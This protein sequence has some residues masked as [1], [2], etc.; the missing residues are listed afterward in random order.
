[1]AAL[2]F[3]VL[4]IAKVLLAQRFAPAPIPAR[5]DFTAQTVP[6]APRT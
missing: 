5:L 1:M 2:F 6:F 4:L 3:Y